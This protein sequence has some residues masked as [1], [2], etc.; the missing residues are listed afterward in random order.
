MK[1]YSINGYYNSVQLG[2]EIET[3]FR[4]N[5]NAYNGPYA[6]VQTLKFRFK[7]CPE[8]ER[9][10]GFNINVQTIVIFWA[11]RAFVLNTSKY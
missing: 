11:L 9:S 4:L 10:F 8:I 1:Y 2:P 5:F 6:S 7:L 3:S